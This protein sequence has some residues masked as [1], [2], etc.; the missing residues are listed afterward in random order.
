MENRDAEKKNLVAFIAFA[1]FAQD[2]T[3]H[4]IYFSW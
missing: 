2:D 4:N 1:A 3:H